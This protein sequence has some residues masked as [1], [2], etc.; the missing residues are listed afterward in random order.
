[1][2]L[3]V[4]R[5]QI[6]NE[7]IYDLLDIT[8]QPHEI[9]LHEGAGGR[10][11]VGGLRSAEV[12]D[13]RDALALFFE[14]RRLVEGGLLLLLLLLLLLRALFHALYALSGCLRAAAHMHAPRRPSPRERPTA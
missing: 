13:E 5:T 6:Y 12:R 11:V 8:T 10:L 2:L 7:A 14:V 3:A 4:R 1:M 9:T